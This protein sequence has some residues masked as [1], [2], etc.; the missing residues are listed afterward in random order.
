MPTTLIG[1]NVTLKV[2]NT[3]T[4]S[5]SCTGSATTTL[6]TVPANSYF[7]LTGIYQKQTGSITVDDG[8]VTIAT[9]SS[10]VGG[11]IAGAGGLYLGAGQRVRVQNN[12][13]TDTYV[14]C[15]ILITNSP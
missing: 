13:A 1:N 7:I 5:L 2:G 3:G 11:Y 10:A 8:S 4:T 15:G 6:Y 9:L 14:L 12:G